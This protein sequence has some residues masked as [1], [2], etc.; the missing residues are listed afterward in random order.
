MSD[1]SMKAR[2]YPSAAVIAALA[3]VSPP[4][5]DPD[6]CAAATEHYKPT[7]EAVMSALHKYESCVSASNGR[8]HCGTEIQAL[9][10]AHD[11]FD[12]AVSDIEKACGPK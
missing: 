4:N 10:N 2:L 9:D 3:V 6:D 1:W 5:T 12:D 11:D 7:V 8:D